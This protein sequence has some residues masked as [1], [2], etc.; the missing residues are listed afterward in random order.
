MVGI[1]DL[2]SLDRNGR[3]GSSPATRTKLSECGETENTLVLDTSTLMSLRVQIPPFRPNIEFMAQLADASSSNG[4]SCNGN[5]GSN[6]N[7]LTKYNQ[8]M[9]ELARH[10]TLRM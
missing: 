1:R 3:A 7:G 4:D 5:L 8:S 6:P 9:M 10:V 2:K